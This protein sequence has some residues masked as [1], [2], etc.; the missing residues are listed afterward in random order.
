MAPR[1]PKPGQSLAD[2][3]PEI[4]AQADGWDPATVT[5]G[6]DKRVVWKCSKGHRWETAINYRT[7]GS[8]C[9]Y[10]SRHRVIPGVTDLATMHPEIAAQAD[11]WD[12]ATLAPKSNKSRNWRCENNHVW[13]S[14]VANRTL[15]HGCPLCSGNKVETGV[16]DLATTNPELANQADGWDP[17]TMSTFSN[18]RVAWKCE[19]GH[20]WAAIINNR[21]KGRGCPVC[22]GKKILPGFNDLAT[23]HPAIATQAVGWDPTL[24]SAGSHRKA[25][26]KCPVGH[27]WN[28]TIKH[29]TS[30]LNCPYCSGK[31]LLKGFNDLATTHPELAKQAVD[32]D[33]T[34]YQ[35]GSNKKVKWRCY[36]GHEWIAWI[37]NRSKGVGC[38]T[39]ANYSYD[40]NKDAWLYLI[41]N[42][43]LSMLQIGISNFIERRLGNHT[44][45]EWEVL[46]VRGPM[47]GRLAQQLETAIL[48]AIEKRG[49][50][51]GHKAS[52]AKFDG[53]SEA[54][55]KASLVITSFKELLDFVYEDDELPK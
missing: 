12:A 54:W 33:P 20:T 2:L 22:S 19:L 23:I 36:E 5:T 31:G 39:C 30:G 18:K 38:P 42:D 46:E 37:N 29:R 32:W 7:N 1:L 55:T 11:G 49:A 44:K 52:I 26:W 4:A 8:G 6:S 9:P 48:H 10:C 50:A 35:A 21:S 27:T 17:T 16:N 15:G 40:P 53:Y 3:F 45:R 51:L 28:T 34:C 14:T 25:L 24:V 47:E 41:E 13:S 43:D